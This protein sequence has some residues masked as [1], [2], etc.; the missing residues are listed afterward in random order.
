MLQTLRAVGSLE[1]DLEELL[2]LHRHHQHQGGG[3]DDHLDKSHLT[4]IC[5][6]IINH[7]EDFK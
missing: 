4:T 2:H 6:I 7:Y 1:P 5:S 3:S